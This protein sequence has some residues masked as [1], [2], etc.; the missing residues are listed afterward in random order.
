MWATEMGR[1]LLGDDVPPD[2]VNIIKEGH[3]GWPYC[4]D[5]KV[6]DKETNPNNSKFDCN[7]TI[8]PTLKLQAHS[9][10]LGLAFYNG[11][12]LVSYHGSWNRSIPTGYK[13]VRF[14]NN[15]Q[16][17]FITG[18]LLDGKALGRPADII[19]DK[20]TNIYISDDKTGVVYRVVKR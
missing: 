13:V 1:D 14:V 9:A 18:W 8:L 7:K 17:D 5:N 11:D 10:P 12:L 3:F 15:K 2:E 19:V 4:Y 16:E 6:P 20:N